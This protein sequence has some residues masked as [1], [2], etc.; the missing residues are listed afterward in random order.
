M[1]A[2]IKMYIGKIVAFIA[3]T[4]AT[5]TVVAFRVIGQPTDS[6]KKALLADDNDDDED[7]EEERR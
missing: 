3:G 5:C 7:Y 4:D 2:Y 1:Q 6:R